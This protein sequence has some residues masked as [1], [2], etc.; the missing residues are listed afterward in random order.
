M[1]CVS[2]RLGVVWKSMIISRPASGLGTISPSPPCISAVCAGCH[3][4]IA[5][6]TRRQAL[7]RRIR[8]CSA[9]STA[10]ASNDVPLSCKRNALTS[11]S[12]R[13]AYRPGGCLSSSERDAL[14]CRASPWS[15]I[16]RST[17]SGYIRRSTCISFP[18]IRSV[19]AWW[20]KDYCLTVCCPQGFRSLLPLEHHYSRGPYIANMDWS[21]RYRPFW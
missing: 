11:L 12:V 15:P 10:L 7:S 17:V 21:R 14:T 9:S 1:N 18:V 2:A 3:V 13:I 4:S 8:A 16:M 19:T 5:G 6:F 20:R